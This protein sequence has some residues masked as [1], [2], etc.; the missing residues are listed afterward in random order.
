[1]AQF[2]IDKNT[3]GTIFSSSND[4]DKLQV[5]GTAFVFLAN[6]MVLTVKHNVPS[7]NL[8]I[9]YRPSGSTL[10]IPM[11]IIY[12]SIEKD[13][14]LLESKDDIAENHFTSTDFNKFQPGVNI[15]FIGLNVGLNKYEIGKGFVHL[16][17]RY[18]DG[19][20]E[21][22]DIIEFIND[23]I[24]SGFSGGPILD[25][26][27]KVIAI[28]DSTVIHNHPYKKDNPPQ[29]F[30]KGYSVQSAVDFFNSNFN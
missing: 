29:Q 14:V 7:D 28:I 12:E 20:V 19:K 17:G 4:S 13:L 15:T 16:K 27:G 6:N 8:K 30:C 1:M 18:L 5:R 2:K 3:I 9:Y 23:N 10:N 21:D 26:D 11:K 25:S 24:K 22:V